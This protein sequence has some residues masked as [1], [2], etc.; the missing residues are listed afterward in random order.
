MDALNTELE[1]IDIILGQPWLRTVNP[2][3]DWSTKTIRDRKTGE[4]VVSS[5]EYT[6]PLALYHLEVDAVAKLLR[7]QPAYLFVIGL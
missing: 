6:L 1:E 2:E 4:A 3:I 7:Q 5:N